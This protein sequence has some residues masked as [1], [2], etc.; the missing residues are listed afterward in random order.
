MSQRKGVIGGN[1]EGMFKNFNPLQDVQSYEKILNKPF[2]GRFPGGANAKEAFL[3]QN[4]VGLGLNFDYLKWW[5]SVYNTDENG[6]SSMSD[7]DIQKD[8]NTDL[9]QNESFL[10]KIIDFSNTFENLEL[11]YNLNVYSHKYYGENAIIDQINVIQ[12]L[13]DNNVKIKGIV[14][15]NE[16]YFV[17][18]TFEE[19]KDLFEPLYLACSQSFPDIPFGLCVSSNMDSDWNDS[20]FDY[21]ESHPQT[22]WAVDTHLYYN[23]KKLTSSTD[24][25][26][27]LI[28]SGQIVLT[29]ALSPIES[30]DTIFNQFIVDYKNSINYHSEFADYVY[31][32][33]PDNVELWMSEYGC[34]PSEYWSNTVAQGA[35]LFESII[36]NS[37]KYDYYLMQNLQG[38]WLWGAISQADKNLDYNPENKDNLE[39]V[40]LW[41]LQMIQEM[42]NPIFIDLTLGMGFLEYSKPGVY[43]I[44]YTNFTKQSLNIPLATDKNLVVSSIKNRFVT[45]MFPY[46]SS[47]KTGFYSKSSIQSYHVNKIYEDDWLSALPSSYGYARIELVEIENKKPVANAGVDQTV[48]IKNGVATVNLSGDASYDEDGFLTKHSWLNTSNGQQL[49]GSNQTVTFYKPGVYEFELVVTDDKGVLSDVDKVKITIEAESTECE[50]CKSFWYYV[51]NYRKCKNCK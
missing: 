44:A 16:L 12:Y 51:F 39:R 27:T 18:K 31:V 46:S 23:S 30:L 9:S 3:N 7:E 14:A 49:I 34:I 19:Y 15:G 42:E 2:A 11:I 26:K 32:N 36:K 10:K 8:V 13:I 25:F 47:G 29:D 1:M 45:G 48:K 33:V 17:V 28:P 6:N 21:I 4:T 41:S 43:Y 50:K 40:G 22:K 38:G 24:L 37:H 5:Y 20:V 35:C